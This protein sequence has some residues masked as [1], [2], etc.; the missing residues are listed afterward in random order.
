MKT[1]AK[2][3][4]HSDEISEWDTIFDPPKKCEYT[5][6]Q[7]IRFAETWAKLKVEEFKLKT[8]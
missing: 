3:F 1:T 4:L 6:E 5:E 7:L 8:K 2:E